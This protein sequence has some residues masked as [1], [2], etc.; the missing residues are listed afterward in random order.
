MKDKKITGEYSSFAEVAQTFGCKPVK[1]RT[2]VKEKLNNQRARFLKNCVCEG[3]KQPMQL[4]QGTNIM[5]CVNPDCNGVEHVRADDNG[6]E[7][8]TYSPSYRMLEEKGALVANN[9]FGDGQYLWLRK[10]ED[11]GDK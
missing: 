10:F 6:N 1:Y 8:K 9:I 5:A 2:S 7:Y 4:I 11:M 3:C